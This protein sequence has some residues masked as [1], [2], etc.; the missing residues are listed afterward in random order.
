[1]SGEAA[2]LVD[3]HAH[4]DAAEFAA[5]RD[6][7]IRRATAA[8]VAAAVTVGVDLDSSRA[9]LALAERNPMLV[10]VVG[11]HPHYALRCDAA[12][13]GELGRLAHH[14][15]VVG[16]GET[17][18]DY[19]RNRA[20]RDVQRSAFRAQLRVSR[21]LGLP[22]IVHDR[23]AHEDVLRMLEEEAGQRTAG[24]SLAGVLHCFS[25]DLAMAQ[26]ALALGLYVSIAG[27]VTYPKAERLAL[28]ARTVPATHLLVETDCP[29]LAP[30]P[31]RGQRN[32]P[33]YVRLTAEHIAAL[34]SQS[35]AELARQTTANALRLF[36]PRLPAPQAGRPA[37]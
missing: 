28:V 20:P 7:V 36:G 21:D 34:R 3:S 24:H 15:R 16:I 32:E 11:I 6:E 29:F 17:G 13:L 33:A 18:L 23:E 12:S 26:A 22:V 1:V 30:Q 5:D 35:F 4:L 37:G 10:A 25:G 27:P 19:Y 8:G 9:A 31:V 14:D 2:L